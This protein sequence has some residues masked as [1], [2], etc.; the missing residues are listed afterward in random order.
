MPRT[1]DRRP[2]PLE[3]DEEIQFGPNPIPP[4]QD[5]A[6]NYDGSSF[7]ARDSVGTFNVRQEVELSID[8]VDQGVI[9]TLEVPTTGGISASIAGTVA[10]LVLDSSSSLTETTHAELRQLIHLADGVGGPFEGFITG[11]YRTDVGFPFRTSTTWFIDNT[12]AQKI[13]EKTFTY[14]GAFP[15]TI[16]WKAYNTDGTTVLAIATDTITYSGAME[17]HRTRTIVDYSVGTT[18]LNE[19]NHKTLRQLIHLASGVG[20]PMEGFAS[21]AYRETLPLASPFPTSVTWY[22]DNTKAKKI[23]EKLITYNANKTINTLQWKAYDVD[24][25]TVLSTATDSLAYS[26]VFSPNRTRGIS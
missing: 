23:V 3:E 24:G 25:V 14:S 18:F 6:V 4:T 13:V 19:S 9:K 22:N 16:T 17:L 2:G 11:A 21:G 10:T 15:A 7:L 20:G 12:M 5:G 8:G 1:P 26:S